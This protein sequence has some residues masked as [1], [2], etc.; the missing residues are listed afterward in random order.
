MRRILSI[1]IVL[2][3]FLGVSTSAQDS[4]GTPIDFNGT[5]DSID[6]TTVVVTGLT[7]DVSGIDPTIIGQLEVGMAI[8]VSGTL[9]NGLVTASVIVLPEPTVAEEPIATE[10]QEEVL[11][12]PVNVP[13]N[14]NYT[15]S[16]GGSSYDGSQT[17]FTYTITGTG[18]PTALSHFDLESHTV[19]HL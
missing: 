6:G 4:S 11:S 10:V 7:V 19:H 15:V 17:T 18:V 13:T 14:A 2:T 5:V 12:E 9:E 3:L 8:T 1:F 16:F